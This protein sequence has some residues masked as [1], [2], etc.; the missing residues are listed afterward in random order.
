MPGGTGGAVYDVGGG[1]RRERRGSPTPDQRKEGK[2]V[3]VCKVI[4]ER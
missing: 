1:E 3:Y 2:V 4:C